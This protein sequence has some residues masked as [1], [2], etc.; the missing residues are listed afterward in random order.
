MMLSHLGH[1]EAAQ[2]VEAA[3]E[4]AL[5]ERAALTPD[6]GGNASTVALG[7]AIAEA[8]QRVS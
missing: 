8:V 1:E 6:M 3:I 7:T 2:A 5:A 4:A